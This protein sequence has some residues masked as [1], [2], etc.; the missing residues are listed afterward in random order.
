MKWSSRVSYFLAGVCFT[1][2]VPHLVIAATGR[3]NLTPFG[4]DSSPEV[5]LLWS[6]INFASGYLL[7]R[8]ADKHAGDSSAHTTTWLVPYETGRFC[9]SLFGV[10]YAWLTAGVKEQKPKEASDGKIGGRRKEMHN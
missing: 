10:F 3:R 7:V 4:R 2:A 8:I 5:N 6:G 9:W 1:N